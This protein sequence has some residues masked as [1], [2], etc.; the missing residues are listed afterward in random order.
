MGKI[1]QYVIVGAVIAGTVYLT[2]MI[3]NSSTVQ[4]Q[5]LSST[6][7]TII[8]VASLGIIGVTALHLTNKFM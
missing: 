8:R 4:S 7:Q 5:K 2:D 3:L 6:T 1:K